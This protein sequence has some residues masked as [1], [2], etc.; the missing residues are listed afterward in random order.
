MAGEELEAPAADL[1]HCDGTDPRFNELLAARSSALEL[2]R[3][4]RFP[5]QYRMTGRAIGQFWAIWK[6]ELCRDFPLRQAPTK[7]LFG[8]CELQERFHH[9]VSSLL[10]VGR[11]CNVVSAEHR[12]D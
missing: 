1:R 5:Q 10:K 8:V 2:D 3:I 6:Q 12:L 11:V 7:L 9:K 4:L